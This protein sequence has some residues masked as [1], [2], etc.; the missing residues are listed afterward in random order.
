MLFFNILTRLTHFISINFLFIYF[1]GFEYSR[2]GN[3]TRNVLEACLAS[4]D[5][6]KHAITF[7]SGLATSNTIFGLLSA[8]DHII[9]SDDLYGGTNRLIRQ[10]TLRQGVIAD[11]VDA[12]NPEIV[13]NAIKN[14]TKL[15]WLETPTN[16]MMKVVDI[17]LVCNL[18]HGVRKDVR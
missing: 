17:E 16:P 5:N 3:P 14:N 10:V 18:V 13:K 9:A 6:G 4:L 12:A 1:Q 7:A 8:G 2:S 11:F 15:V